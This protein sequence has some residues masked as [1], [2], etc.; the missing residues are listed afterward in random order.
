MCLLYEKKKSVGL[1]WPHGNGNGSVEEELGHELELQK[2]GKVGQ[3]PPS[4]EKQCEQRLAGSV[5]Q[6]GSKTRLEQ[7]F[8]PFST[9]WSVANLRIFAYTWGQ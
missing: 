1:K 3:R 5:R 6:G 8:S 7:D 2:L 9:W 4:W